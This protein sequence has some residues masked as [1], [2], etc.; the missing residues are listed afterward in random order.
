[1]SN[2]SK[3]D[4]IAKHEKIRDKLIELSKTSE[5]AC[6][7]VARLAS[8]LKMDGRTVR[9][10]LKIMEIDAMGA[11]LDDEQKQFCTKKGITLLANTLR[12]HEKDAK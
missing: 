8:E 5:Y 9:A 11:F 1:M 2:K 7:S 10:H 6:F 4:Y 12:A 3:R